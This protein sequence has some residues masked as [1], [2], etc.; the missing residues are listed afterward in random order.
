MV[1]TADDK[2]KLK[3]AS[4]DVPQMLSCHW[5]LAYGW[6]SIPSEGVA[7]YNY[8][9]AWMTCELNEKY[10]HNTPSKM[11]HLYTNSH[12][13]LWYVIG[14]HELHTHN[15]CATETTHA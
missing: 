10:V 1:N 13:K 11:H 14:G 15:N 4:N 3:C 7:L 2:L 12:N 8:T 9:N 5:Q 6:H